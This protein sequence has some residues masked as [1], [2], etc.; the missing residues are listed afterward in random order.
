MQKDLKFLFLFF[1]FF[2]TPKG[3]FHRFWNRLYTCLVLFGLLISVL[4]SR[5]VNFFVLK[6]H[7]TMIGKKKK[8]VFVTLLFQ[9]PPT[10][11][12]KI[13]YRQ[14]MCAKIWDFE[15]ERTHAFLSRLLR[16]LSLS[17][18]LSLST[19][20]ALN[21]FPR[22]RCKNLLPTFFNLLILNHQLPNCH[23]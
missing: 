19:S 7:L 17:L 5:L 15:R 20:F 2:E 8:C 6:S 11:K 22:A 9:P 4:R 12:D 16:S 21:K 14:R 13:F 3:L 18:T 23:T 1:C 10:S